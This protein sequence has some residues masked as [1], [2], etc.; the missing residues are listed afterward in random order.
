MALFVFLFFPRGTGA[1]LLAP[2]Q[3][4]A[5]QT[6]SGFS[7]NVSFQNIARISQNNE[8]VAHV[9]V[10]HRLNQNGSVTD[11]KPVERNRKQ[12][13]LRRQRR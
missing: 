13:S 2:L 5:S 8:V 4:R 12:F 7:D 9:R 6:L 10:G 1:N 3:Q 11:Q